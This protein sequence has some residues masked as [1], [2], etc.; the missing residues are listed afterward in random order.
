MVWV[1]FPKGCMRATRLVCKL[2][3]EEIDRL[4]SDEDYVERMTRHHPFPTPWR[5]C[6][7][8][9]HC[10]VCLYCWDCHCARCLSKGQ[11]GPQL[12]KPE[13]VRF[14]ARKQR[15]YVTRKAVC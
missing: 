10:G 3:A 1:R 14:L 11:A 8:L 5:R 15:G 2:A 7:A 9:W 13:M 4:E 6:T 12:T